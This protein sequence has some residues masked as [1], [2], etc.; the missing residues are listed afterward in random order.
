MDAA[1]EQLGKPVQFVRGVGPRRADM[2]RR[3][4]IENVEQ[5]LY[6]L[7]FR[8]EDRRTV[9]TIREARPGEEAGIVGEIV[10][11]SDRV[12]G[13]AR[14]R[15]L[16]GVLRDETG[17]LGLTWYNQ[18]TYFRARYRTGQK[19]LVYGRVEQTPGGG[20]RIVHPEVD[21][22]PG[23]TG[24]GVLAV[25]NKPTTM[26]VAAM[27]KM[28]REAVNGFVDLVPSALPAEVAAAAGVTDLANALRGVHEPTADSDIDALNAFRSTA[29]RSLVFDELFFLQLGLAL[30]RRSIVQEDGIR[31]EGSGTLTE[32]LRSLLPFTLTGAQERVLAD[33]RADMA[34]PH[35]MNRLVHGD[36]GSGKTIVALHAALIAIENGAQAA[37]MAPTELLAEQH[38]RTVS[39][40]T[41]NLGVR[42]VLL[43]GDC[44][45]AEKTRIY[46]ELERG[47]IKLVVGT[48]AL[49]QEGVRIPALGLGVIDE[50][51]RFGVL[52]RAALRRL[53]A[54]EGPTPDILLMTATPIPRTLAM[55]AYGDLDV[56]ALDEL[57][58]GRKPIRTM[59]FNESERAR[60]YDLVKR[61][62]DSGRQAYVVYPLV[63]TSEKEDLRDA[64]T[65]EREFRDTV[66]AGRSVGLI[67]G[68]MK[69]ED[70][71][72]V[73][74]RFRDG[75]L[76][77]LVST[78]VI[79]VGV[80]VPNATMMVIEH[81]ERFGLSQL[82]QLRGRVGRGSEGGTC[83][84]IA[85][86]HRGEDVYRRLQAMRETNDGFR[87]AEVDL[88]LRGPGEFLGTRQSGLPDFR[89]ANLV[90]DSRILEQAR[91]AVDRWLEKDP[92]LERPESAAL[93]VVLKHRWAGRLGLAQIG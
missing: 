76:Q 81:A 33:I 28:V 45:R 78:T 2:L 26:T 30:R 13:R 51:H 62:I 73:M 40:Y 60:V 71:D 16:E 89:V 91:R 82:H 20:K 3:F 55:T 75:Q 34:Q 67:H 38:F 29:H 6:H 90:R 64:T 72:A 15:I 69:S 68:R 1:L 42:T 10:Q 43:T 5:L 56:S 31:L 92:T 85:P 7:P 32:R 66:F 17:L 63:E 19:C 23:E 21:L 48:H 65:M 25:Y 50:Q 37:F 86:Y 35:P 93:R 61:E 24:Q 9:R 88:D 12:V 57:P 84:L 83:L 4:G 74:R 41:E 14:R 77:L 47:D 80:D 11:L 44:T 49:I 79:E 70:K 8:Y 54:E 27:R 36:V 39:Q 22:D 53:R 59:I 52:Q 18:V 58:P 46:A 87:I